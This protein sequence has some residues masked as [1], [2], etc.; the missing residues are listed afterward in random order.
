MREIKI[1]ADELSLALLGLPADKRVCILDSCGVGHLGSHLMI[2]GVSPVD[3]AEISNENAGV[4]LRLFEEKL[5]D[6]SLAAIFTLSYDFG[7]KL[8]QFE[9]R[10]NA[11]DIN[12]PDVFI[13]LFDCLIVHDYDSGRTF[14]TGNEDKFNEIEKLLNASRFSPRSNIST[15]SLI[16][17]FTK[18]EYVA[19]VVQ[20]QEYIRRGDTYQTNLT[21]QL[22]AVLPDVSAP[23]QIFW[24]LRRDHPAPFSAFLRRENSTVVSASPER[25]IKI[26]KGPFS[27]FRISASP[28][29]GTRPRG[30]TAMEDYSLR[31]ELLASEKDRAENT[32]IVDLVRNDLGRICRYGSVT[33][34]SLCDLEVH[35]TL[36]HLVSTVSGELREN[37]TLGEIIRA[38]FPCGSITGAPK[39]RTMELIDRIETSKRGLS[40]GVIGIHVRGTESKVQ[41]PK[42]KVQDSQPWTLDFGLSTLVEMSVAIR[43]MVVSGNEAVFNVGGGIVID[44]DPD[45]EYDESLLKAKALITALGGSSEFQL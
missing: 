34:E 21:Q 3:M 25:L 26:E 8:E 32:M 36:F 18:T 24:N 1:S 12:E 23:E 45:K 30:K 37:L 28:I 40:M 27:S 38:V 6:D 9:R 7:L 13:A 17:N 15:I 42:P 10:Q 33:V 29:K 35:P 41:S 11:H 14:L 44:S 16:S 5:K 43:T 20:I 4:T 31:A 39:I 19:A 2:A 22:R